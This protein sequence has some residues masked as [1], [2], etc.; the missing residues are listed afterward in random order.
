M[1]ESQNYT[2][3]AREAWDEAAPVHWQTTSH[4]LDTISDPLQTHI[5]DIQVEQLRRIGIE[6][7]AVAQLNSNKGVELITI[8][9]L[10]AG[11]CVGFDISRGFTDHAQQFASAAGVE[12]EF[13][14]SDVYDIP[15]EYFQKFDVVVITAG[16]LCF[17]PDLNAYFRVAMNLLR[18]N[19]RLAI[20][21]S[22]P[23]T[24]M[25]QMDR[26]AGGHPVQMVNSYFQDAPLLR[27]KGLDYE[28]GTTYDAKP[29]YYFFHTLG[30]IITGVVDAG[31][32]IER[33]AEHD[34]DPS[35]AVTSLETASVK[36]PLSFTLTAVKR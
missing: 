15:T 13:V 5:H 2:N 26:D 29:I 23:V 20:Y 19:G 10:G 24:R 18:K 6:G 12:C 28:G 9:R 32:S 35:K 30:D 25:F 1:T 4:L 16:A 31:F 21:E 22:H 8:K 34:K 7:K 11:R 33:F 14:C 17:M 27:T 3:L 36:P